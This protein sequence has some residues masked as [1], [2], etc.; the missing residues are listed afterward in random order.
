MTAE[1]LRVDP[2]ARIRRSWKIITAP[3]RI[4]RTGN[5]T[6]SSMAVVDSQIRPSASRFPLRRTNSR[7]NG[8]PARSD[9]NRLYRQA[10]RCL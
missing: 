7:L 1:D 2:D 4:N 8:F 3:G 6:L 10:I 5:R 9:L